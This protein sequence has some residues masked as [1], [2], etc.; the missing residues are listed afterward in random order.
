MTTLSGTP[1]RLIVFLLFCCSATS[2]RRGGDRSIDETSRRAGQDG[3]GKRCAQSAN[4]ADQR[5]KIQQRLA[6]AEARLQQL[7]DQVADD[8]LVREVELLK[9]IDLIF[10]NCQTSFERYEELRQEADQLDEELRTNALPQQDL[11]FVQ[12]DELRDRLILE[13]ERQESIQLEIDAARAALE[14]A[15]RNKN[16]NDARRRLT[17]DSMEKVRNPE[18]LE[19]ARREVELQQLTSRAY[20]LTAEQLQLELK[21]KELERQITGKRADSYRHLVEIAI[22]DSPFST[23]DLDA[24]IEQVNRTGAEL[25]GIIDQV[26]A[27]LQAADRAWM[28]A[29]QSD[30]QD[31]EAGQLAAE[32][33]SAWRHARDLRQERLSFLKQAGAYV[34][35]VCNVW[36]QRH[37][38]ANHAAT[39]DDFVEWLD[40]VE[41]HR[42]ELSRFQRLL[43]IRAN[44]HLGDAAAFKKRLLGGTREQDEVIQWVQHQATELDNTIEQYTTLM[45][46]LKSA[47]RLLKRF[48]EDLRREIEPTSARQ[49]VVYAGQL[50]QTAWNYEITSVDDRAI[51]VGKICYG[52]L[53]SLA[54]FVT[55]RLLSRALG[56]RVLPKFGLTQ[57]AQAFQSM[58][59]YLMLTCFGVVSLEMINIPLTVFAFMGGAIAIGV[60]F[61]SQNILNNFI[62]G[63]IVL[64]ERPIRVGDLVEISGLTGT[65]AHIAHEARE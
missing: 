37:Q 58:A 51:T 28:E 33:L 52:L 32:Q 44:E 27:D 19:Q 21:I 12:L 61:G 46:M 35:H 8:Y 18:K 17:R 65:I 14:I 9:W 36:R 5:H 48:V 55:A 59:F 64:A 43:S 40:D 11:S 57:G 53:L 29:K 41:V 38:L 26:Q 56:R 7:G 45:V 60:G 1:I 50:M 34:G 42:D 63:L 2:R 3:D 30:G 24:K 22:N 6:R 4:F 20:A 15:R 39:R 54:G 23:A 62:S 25:A 13:D 10:S 16:E 47:D 31:S 49:A